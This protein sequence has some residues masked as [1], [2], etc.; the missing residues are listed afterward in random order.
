MPV[1]TN[2]IDKLTPGPGNSRDIPE[3]ECDQDHLNSCGLSKD[4]T[5][6]EISGTWHW[7]MVGW[8]GDHPVYFLVESSSSVTAISDTFTDA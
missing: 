2:D 4:D 7:F 6:L 5:V 8:I 1:E 3:V